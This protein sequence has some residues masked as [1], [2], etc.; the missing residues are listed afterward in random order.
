MADAESLLVVE[1]LVAS[2]GRI[3]AVRG[4]SFAV[5]PGE[6]VAVI[7]ANGAGKTT[8]LAA[9]SGLVRPRSGRI[10]WMGEEISTLP[11]ETIVRRGLAHCPEG[12]RIFP[13]LTVREN[14]I[15]GA[16]ARRHDKAEVAQDLDRIF[17]LFPRLKERIGQRGWSLSGGEQQ[18][19]AIGR[20]LMSRPKL[21]MLDE[22]SL[23]LAPIIIE[24]MFDRI[25]ELNRST[26][27][28][29]LLVEQN[30]AMALEISS[31]ALVLEA[32]RITLSGSAATLA[33]DPRIV[34][35]YLGG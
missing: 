10:A 20:A 5:N 9:I 17:D 8:T 12:R 29:I 3:E 25:L 28:A 19:L 7:G 4:I 14:L 13:G 16:S 21:L 30:S 35:A 1:N 22:P 26:G 34:E 23:G 33:G 32:G 18:M 11:V 15:S 6:I 2:Y 31:R 24:Q 27:L